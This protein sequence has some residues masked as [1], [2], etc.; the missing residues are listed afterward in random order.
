LTGI[1]WWPRSKSGWSGAARRVRFEMRDMHGPLSATT[2]TLY[3]A[4]QIA[5]RRWKNARVYNIAS[6]A[7]IRCADVI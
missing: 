2:R 7:G 1:R 5:I 4:T 3:V 6:E